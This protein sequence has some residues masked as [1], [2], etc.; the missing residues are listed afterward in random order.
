MGN[1]KDECE[2]EKAQLGNK[3]HLF[4]LELN[5]WNAEGQER[6]SDV[7]NTECLTTTSHLE[8]LSIR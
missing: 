7:K 1:M 4:H 5:F 6:K 3:E 8:S 2:A